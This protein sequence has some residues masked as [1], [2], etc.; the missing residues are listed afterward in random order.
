MRRLLAAIVLTVCATVATPAA[1]SGWVYAC[2]STAA[3]SS[4][5][6][7]RC[8]GAGGFRVVLRCHSTVMGRS[9]YEYGRWTIAPFGESWALCY[10]GYN[11]AVSSWWVQK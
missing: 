11:G 9:W 5:K 10:D 8:H 3:S 7:A 1:A 2:Y 6:A 4:F